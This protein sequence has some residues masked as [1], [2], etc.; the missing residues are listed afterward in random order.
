MLHQT[1]LAQSLPYRRET[2]TPRLFPTAAGSLRAK[3]GVLPRAAVPWLLWPLLA[4]LAAV[5][6]I[7]K[8]PTYIGYPPFYWGEAVVLAAMVWMLTSR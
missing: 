5:L 3:P 8:G 1:Q 6:I 4:Y 2:G 7:G